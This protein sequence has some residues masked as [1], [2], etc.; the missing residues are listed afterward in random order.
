VKSTV[1]PDGLS[2]LQPPKQADKAIE[3]AEN[4]SADRNSFL[5]IV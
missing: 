5:S 3:A 2:F 4:P 1:G